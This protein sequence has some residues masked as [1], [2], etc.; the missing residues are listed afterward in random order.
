VAQHKTTIRAVASFLFVLISAFLSQISLAGAPVDLTNR[1][2]QGAILTA[3][4]AAVGIAFRQWSAS[5]AT[6]PG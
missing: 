1:E 6:A 4:L 2:S 3:L 5:P